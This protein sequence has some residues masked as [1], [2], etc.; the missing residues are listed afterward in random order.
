ML[1]GRAIING[2]CRIKHESKTLKNVG[3]I[4]DTGNYKG[5][6]TAVHELGHL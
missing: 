5:I 2:A 1:I 3:I 4:H 6:L